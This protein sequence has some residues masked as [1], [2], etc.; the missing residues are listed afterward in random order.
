MRLNENPSELA[1]NPGYQYVRT[2]MPVE[3]FISLGEPSSME[4]EKLVRRNPKN[5][6]AVEYL[7]AYYLLNGDLNKIWSRLSDLH[8]SGFVQVPRH[9]QEALLLY[10]ALIPK[11]DV[12][13]LNKWIHPLVYRQFIEYEQIIR[14]HGGSLDSAK[15]D[16]QNRFGETYWYYMMFVKS[17]SRRSENQNDFQ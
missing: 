11:F 5:R 2:C 1:K 14:S 4:L 7:F 17:A 6:M 3:D 16:L 12:N 8:A 15:Q 9:V 10:A 13:Q